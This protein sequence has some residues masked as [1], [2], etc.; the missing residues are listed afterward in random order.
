MIATRSFA[1]K[2]HKDC[3]VGIDL[4]ATLAT[5]EGWKGPLS[6][7]RPIQSTVDFVKDLVAAGIQVKIFTARVA[8]QKEDNNYNACRL[9]I[10]EWCVAHL[11]FSLPVTH[12]KDHLLHCFLD[13]KAIQVIPNT[14][15]FCVEEIEA[16]KA[17]RDYWMSLVHEQTRKSALPHDPYQPN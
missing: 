12:A 7:G 15:E 17:S 8:P 13:D 1:F 9:A 2:C 16:L 3:W 10:E 5:Y 4:D 11:G 6:I 14:G